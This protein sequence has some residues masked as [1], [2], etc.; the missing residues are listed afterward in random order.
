[1]IDEG[2]PAAWPLDVLEALRAFKQGS[3]VERP[4]IF[5]MAAPAHGIWDL[6][7]FAGT[8][9]LAEDLIEL[10]ERDRPSHGLITTQTCDIAEEDR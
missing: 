6:T 7:C 9:D 8:Q 1:M 3:L 4:P 5:Y 10:A 2:L